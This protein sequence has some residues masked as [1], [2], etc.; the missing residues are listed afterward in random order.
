MNL[1]SFLNK[2]NQT[3]EQYSR[4]ELLQIIHEIARTLP[5]NGRTDFLKQ[6]QHEKSNVHN[7]ERA[8][9]ELKKQYEKCNQDLSAIE[10][11]EVRL[12]E[13]YND[14]YDDWYNSSA[15][16][17]LYEDT[18][19]I[20]DMIQSVCRFIHRCVDLGEYKFALKTGRRLFMQ[21]ILTDD[22]YMTGPLEL[23]AFIR[24]NEVAVDLKGTAL[25]TL[26]AC[27]QVEKTVK[28]T[29]IMYEIW[30]NAGIL[31]LKLEDVMQYGEEGLS[32][33]DKFL[34][35][36]ITYL[37]EKK[38]KLAERLY[39]EAVNLTDDVSLKFEIA[40]KYVEFH[41]GMYKEILDDS[42]INAVV[43]GEDGLNRINRKLCVRSDVA[44]KTAEFALAEGKDMQA[45]EKYYIEAFVS[46]TNAVNYLRAFLNST[47]KEK[48]REKLAFIVKNPSNINITSWHEES[49][50][51]SEL[52]ENVLKKEML[53]VLQF[54]NGQFMEVLEKRVSEKSSLGWT[55]TFMK[56]GLA[57]FLLFL[58]DGK[59]LQQGSQRMLELTKQAFR[60]T[61]E[62][63]KKGQNLNIEKTESEYFYELFLK[64]K[65]TARIED[66]D[67]KKILKHI[68]NLMKKRV[69]A[70]MGASRR[71]YYGECAAYIAAI[72]EVKEML[73]EKN[74][75]QIYISQYADM[76]PRRRSFK[77][78]LKKYGWISM[79]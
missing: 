56:E 79:C 33:F 59:E 65:D 41:P 24:Y 76:Y 66:A 69:E 26:Y 35:E 34:P 13:V 29:D 14:E 60:F 77:T 36:W 22:E 21:E 51:L 30:S 11:G 32:E 31:D 19:G 8:C 16:E 73:G 9:I 1:I 18:D 64:W 54:L 62:E 5:E 70:I 74:A 44:L 42:P 27:Y 47:N 15:E 28:R 23:G 50:S 78:E 68:D 72:G 43:I 49:V 63:Y 61:L 17:I 25:D 45:V 20:G 52:S 71:N 3:I 12:Q 75:K 40:K 53:Y 4:S 55:G 6:I 46:R 48:C 7:A 2:V 39:S 58:Y 37:G 67:R 57:V 38:G 10:K